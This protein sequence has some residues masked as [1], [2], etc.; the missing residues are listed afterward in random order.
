MRWAYGVTTV[1]ERRDDLLRN[2]LRSLDNAGFPGPR[3]FVDGATE[4]SWRS[5]LK[6]SDLWKYEATFRLPQIKTFGNWSLALWELLIRVPNADRYAVFQDDFVTYK[7]LREYLERVPYP[8]KGYL[9]LYTFPSNQDLAPAD[10]TGFYESRELDSGDV[11]HGKKQ[12]TGRGA[13]ALVFSRDAVIT[14]LTHLHF[15]L[16]PVEAA[17]PW[18]RVDGCVVN[19]MNKA[20]W[21]EYVHDP[22]LVQHVGKHSSMGSRP[23]PQATSFRGEEFDALEL[24]KERS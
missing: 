1:P 13:V 6:E 22:S 3:L 11:Y 2:T 7:N 5:N 17:E 20:G 8:D 12:Q 23:H 4:I 24:L 14:L 9:N 19:A 21:R 15:V 16:K 10:R 18:K